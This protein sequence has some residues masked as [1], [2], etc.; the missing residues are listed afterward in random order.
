VAD[1]GVGVGVAHEF[2]HCG[3]VSA[4]VKKVAQLQR[5]LGKVEM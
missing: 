1:R 5:E 2:Q 4:G 3:D